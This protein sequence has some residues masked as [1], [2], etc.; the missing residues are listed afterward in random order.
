MIV[1]TDLSYRQLDLKKKPCGSIWIAYLR[2]TL[3]YLKDLSYFAYS[4]QNYLVLLHHSSITTTASGDG[5]RE[6]YLAPNWEDPRIAVAFRGLFVGI[7]FP[8]VFC[9]FDAHARAGLAGL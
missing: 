6:E 5:D 1:T 8:L 3:R 2:R 4:L 7:G 9:W